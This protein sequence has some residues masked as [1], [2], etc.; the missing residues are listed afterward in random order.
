M[1]GINLAMHHFA[2]FSSYQQREL[3]NKKCVFLSHRSVDKDKIVKIGEY[4]KNAGLNIYLDINDSDLQIALTVQSAEKI[5]K[6]IQRG[7]SFSNFMICAISSNTFDDKSW[8]V[9]YEIG[10]CDKENKECCILKLSNLK[11][12]QIPEYLKI[13]QIL[14]NI[15]D[16]NKKLKS[17][18]S[19]SIIEWQTNSNY[20]DRDG[21]LSQSATDHILMGILDRK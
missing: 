10:Y 16:L 21:L 9:P 5:T 18:S 17:W 20:L 6:C 8:W 13:K 12:D 3:K 1:K 14:Y 2:E 4:I 15:S 7:L 11:S 19:T